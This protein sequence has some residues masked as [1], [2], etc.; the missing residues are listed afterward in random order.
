MRST[1]QIAARTVVYKDADVLHNYTLHH[2]LPFRPH[3]HNSDRTLKHT[4]IVLP[5]APK[6]AQTT[7]NAARHMQD[8]CVSCHALIRNATT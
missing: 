5:D 6:D 1:V 3:D 2:P 4:H 7:I 8:N